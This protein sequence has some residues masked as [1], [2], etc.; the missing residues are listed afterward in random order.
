ME[1]WVRRMDRCSTARSFPMRLPVWTSDCN[2]HIAWQ[3]PVRVYCCVRSGTTMDLIERLNSW[4]FSSRAGDSTPDLNSPW[5]MTRYH[6]WIDWNSPRWRPLLSRLAM[7]SHLM[8]TTTSIDPVWMLHSVGSTQ[9]STPMSL[10][11]DRTR[12]RL[13]RLSIKLSQPH[14]CLPVGCVLAV[15]MR[16]IF[17]VSSSISLLDVSVLDLAFALV[18][19]L[20]GRRLISSDSEFFSRA[21]IS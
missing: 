16:C 13:Q 12:Q 5:P 1:S 10:H 19:L 2:W 14:I 3:T 21:M 11:E 7:F 4:T 17:A 6:D 8:T 20:D 18:S 15:Y 9:I